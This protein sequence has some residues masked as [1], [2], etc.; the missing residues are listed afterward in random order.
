MRGRETARRAGCGA[1]PG[2]AAPEKEGVVIP[3]ETE[4]TFPPAF[5]PL[6]VPAELRY[7]DSGMVDLDEEHWAE[8]LNSGDVHAR[9]VAARTLWRG[10]SRGYAK[11][12]LDFVATAPAETESFLALK[13]EVEQ[14]VQPQGILRELRGNDYRWGAWLAFLRPNPGLV[15]VLLAAMKDKPKELPETMLALG[16]SGDHRAFEPLLVRMKSGDD[17]LAGFAAGAL[18]YLADPAAEP[19]LIAALSGRTGWL[20]VKACRARH[21]DRDPPGDSRAQATGRERRLHRRPQHPGHGA[22][23]DRGDFEARKTLIH[24]PD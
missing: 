22:G 18:G 10:H 4:P 21:D 17:R 14:D 16:K 2:S 3:Q 13:R 23:G 20:K 11:D 7:S 24:P 15:P 9:V 1:H 8:V 5:F 6:L 19:E 12:V